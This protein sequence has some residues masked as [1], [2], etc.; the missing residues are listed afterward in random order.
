MEVK[1]RSSEKRG[2]VGRAGWWRVLGGALVTA[3]MWSFREFRRWRDSSCKKGT[4]KDFFKTL[5]LEK[6]EIPSFLLMLL[7]RGEKSFACENFDEL[8]DLRFLNLQNFVFCFEFENL[9]FL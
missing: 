8:L 4:L 2:E 1:K 5:N 7:I 6:V 3:T 9:I